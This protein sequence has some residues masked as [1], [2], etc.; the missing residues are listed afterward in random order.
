MCGFNAHNQIPSKKHNEEQDILSFEQAY[1]SPDLAARCA[2]WSCTVIEVDGSLVYHG[3]RPSGHSSVLI[4]GPPTRNIKAIFGDASGVLGALTT[5]GSLYTFRTTSNKPPEFKKHRF[6]EASFIV[7]QNLAIDQLA[8][9]DSGEVCICSNNAIRKRSLAGLSPTPV[10]SKS[11]PDFLLSPPT[12]KMQLHTFASFEDLLASDPPT[13]TYPLFGPLTSLLASATGFTALTSSREVLTF[14]SALHPQT[15]G[16]TPT[17]ANPADKPCPI[18]F[19]GG[20]PIRKIAVGG[21]I[22]AAVSEDNDL[23]IWGGRAG[24][25]KR[26]NALP[27]S[28]DSEEVK[29]VDIDGGVDVI[30]VGVGSGHVIALTADGK[31]WVAGEGEYG[32][33]GYGGQ[34]FE[35]DW[36]RVRGGWEGRGKVICVGCGVWCSW[37]MVDTRKQTQPKN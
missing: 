15:L 9:A 11:A 33:L 6:S 4:D 34:A 20:I 19:L 29:L 22:G 10:D 3:F 1:R 31:V 13:S 17:P 12:A 32:Q 23:Y 28:T 36:R 26:I 27:R 21:W 30:D 7:R 5:D 2:L 35:E 24:E 18:P 25:A 37:I 16:R 8:I 14:G